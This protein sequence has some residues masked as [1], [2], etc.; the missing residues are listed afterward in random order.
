MN[1]P[2]LRGSTRPARLERIEPAAVAAFD[3]LKSEAADAP[4]VLYGASIG[5]TA[6]L[7]LAAS[8]PVE[9]AGLI[10]HNPPPLREMI[11][12]QFGWW[13]LWL[14]AAPVALQISL[15]LDCISNAR[16]SCVPAF[17]LQSERVVR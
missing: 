4:I 17:C 3:A 8:R 12:R 7:Y 5:V 10:L 11:L 14:L 9:I 6:A 2:G 15:D 16:A 13:N 1:Y